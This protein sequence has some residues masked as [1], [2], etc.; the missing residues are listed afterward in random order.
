M[1]GKIFDKAVL[2]LCLLVFL[3]F[4]FL[5][6]EAREERFRIG[7]PNKIFEVIEKDVFCEGGEGQEKG[8]CF[9]LPHCNNL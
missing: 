2:A 7:Q 6:A 9:T 1:A 5:V 4:Y 3:S 8:K